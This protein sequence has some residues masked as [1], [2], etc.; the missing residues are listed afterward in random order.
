M[1]GNRLEVADLQEPLNPVPLLDRT[2]W[3]PGNVQSVDVSGDLVA[4]AGSGLDLR[5]ECGEI[6]L[7]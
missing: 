3:L 2:H 4:V 7:T 1:G 6:V 5:I